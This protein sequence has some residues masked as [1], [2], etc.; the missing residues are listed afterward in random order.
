MM[1]THEHHFQPLFGNIKR[2]FNGF[3]IWLLFSLTRIWHVHNSCSIYLYLIAE[4]VTHFVIF[5]SEKYW[6]RYLFFR[7]SNY[8]HPDIRYA[9]TL[10]HSALFN[11][12]SFYCLWTI[13]LWHPTNSAMKKNIVADKNH[14][15]CNVPYFGL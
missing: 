10:K 7:L 8:L 12:W 2:K 5:I 3:Q 6:C 15:H 4:R 14:Y 13:L 11:T 1:V 9:L